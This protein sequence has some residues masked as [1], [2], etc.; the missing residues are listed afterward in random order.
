MDAKI[1]AVIID[2]E[3]LARKFIRNLLKGDRSVEI[4]GECGNGREAVS[5]ITEREPD[6]VFLDV[7]MPEMDGF[8]VLQAVGLERLPQIIFTTAYDDYAIRA[9]EVRALDYILK[10]F[11]R[12]RFEQT[13]ARAK[14]RISPTKLE[15]VA[16]RALALLEQIEARSSYLERLAVK[17]DDRVL[18]IKVDGIDW[19]EAEDNYVRLHVGNTSYTIRGVL[20]ELENQLDPKQFL[21]IHR[22]AIVNI[23]CIKELICWF[24]REYRVV[25]HD[26]TELTMSRSY[27]RKLRPIRRVTKS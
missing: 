17:R 10:P 15:Y 6:L 26:G 11:T 2:D 9:F 3:P 19:F 24:N 16:G 14:E 18:L 21:R 25:L 22:R 4:V 23:D 20:N 12:E 5:L 8:S 27:R 7:Q 13:V 1:R